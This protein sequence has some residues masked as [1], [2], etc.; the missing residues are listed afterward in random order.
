M[1]RKTRAIVG[2][3]ALA[4][5][6]AL[7]LSGCGGSGFD[8]SGDSGSGRGGLTSS[9]DALNILIGSS[10]E[11]ETAAVEEAVAAWSEESGVEAK[12]SGGQRSQPAARRRASRRD[13]PPT[14]STCRPTRSPGTPA[15]ARSRPTATSSRTRTTSTPRSW[16]TSR[17][18]ASST[19]HRRTSRRSRLIINT[20]LWTAAGLTEA[21][22]PTTWDELAAVSKTLTTDGRVGLAFGA[23]YQRVGTFMAQA[24]GGHGRRRRSRRQQPRE[25][26]GA[27]VRQVAPRRT[28]RSPTPQTSEPD[29]AARRSASSWPPW[30]SRAT[31]SAAR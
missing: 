24:G 29:G 9:D 28:A 18:T 5:A 12:V 4:V 23:E 20:D 26:R 11:A 17:S 25:R 15:T 10:G 7:V 31:G 16:R 19:V 21:D 30:S 13:R 27:R 22:V 8:D 3:G 14:C 2:A 6:G 1:T